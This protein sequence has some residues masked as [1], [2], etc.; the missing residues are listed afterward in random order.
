MKWLADENLRNA[1]VR[2]LLRRT[3]GFDIVRVQDVPQISGEEGTVVREQY[4]ARAAVVSQEVI[5]VSE[6][7]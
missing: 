1:I 4:A 5:V 6:L 7:I 2:G 3:P